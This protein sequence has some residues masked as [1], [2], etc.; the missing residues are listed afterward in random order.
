[1]PRD[2]PAYSLAEG[3]SLAAHAALFDG[4]A[5]DKTREHHKV[6]LDAS[7]QPPARRASFLWFDAWLNRQDLSGK[8]ALDMGC[9]RGEVSVQ[10][11]RLGARVTGVDVSPESLRR[12]AALAQS[13]GVADLIELREGNAES[14]PFDDDRFDLAVSAGVM[15]FVYFDRAAAELARVTKQGG[16]A[17]ILDTLGHNPIARL[18]RRRRLVHGE[19]TRF[20]VENILTCNHLDRLRA[21]FG[22]VE[23]QAFDFL[24][25]PMMFVEDRLIRLHPK[26]GGIFAPVSATLRAADKF[27]LKWRPL[28]RFAFR[29]VVIAKW[30]RVH[31]AG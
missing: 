27:L 18:G 25:V 14:L 24:A 23:V 12:A 21:H 4:V 31:E 1:M 28:R 13:H 2:E 7:R 5:V 9:G 17:V 26:L 6:P 30:P 11:A 29:V 10:L 19:T 22:H 8:A 3:T 15:S 16:T 20:Q